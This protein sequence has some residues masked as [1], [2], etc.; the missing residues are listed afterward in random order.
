M[1]YLSKEIN[2]L[3]NDMKVEREKKDEEINKL[4]IDNEKKINELKNDMKVEREKKNK[5]IN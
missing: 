2:E 4:K 3:K 1:D 5:K